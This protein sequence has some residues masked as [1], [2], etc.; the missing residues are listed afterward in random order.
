MAALY[1]EA[2]NVVAHTIQH[3]AALWADTATTTGGTI[4]Q[5]DGVYAGPQQGVGTTNVAIHVADQGTGSPDYAIKV[6]GGQNDLG[7]DTT[8][9]GTLIESASLTPSSGST[10]GVTGQIAWDA[11]FIYVCVVGGGAG[12]ATWKKAALVAAL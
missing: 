8:T 12:S 3:T 7:P 10:A 6:D 5:N 11:N 2:S 4:T 1:G 9:A